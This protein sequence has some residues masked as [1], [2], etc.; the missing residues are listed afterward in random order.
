MSMASALRS[1]L[2]CFDDLHIAAVPWPAS[3]VLGQTIT[4]VAFSHR[5][6]VIATGCASGWVYLWKTSFECATER[7]L[8]VPYVVC[9]SESSG[10][11]GVAYCHFV[12]WDT[13]VCI[14]ASV[15]E[16]LVTH[17]TDGMLRLWSVEEGRCFSTCATAAFL[18]GAAI[19]SALLP[20]SRFLVVASTLSIVVL[21]L[22][23]QLP[24]A[25]LA[26][27]PPNN[28]PPCLSKRDIRTASLASVLRL[29]AA[30]H[31]IQH[32]L[33]AMKGVSDCSNGTRSF[34]DSSAKVFKASRYV[35]DASLESLSTNAATVYANATRSK[36]SSAE[37]SPS[38]VV[39]Q[40]SN[41]CVFLWDLT[42][43]ISR[44]RENM[45]SNCEVMKLQQSMKGKF[46]K[47]HN[48]S[49][50]NS[51]GPSAYDS[52]FPENKISR[53]HV[54]IVEPVA[55]VELPDYRPVRLVMSFFPVSIV[56]GPS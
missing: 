33:I 11:G 12:E 48:F 55:A 49:D 25:V 37:V 22:W 26:F 42:L 36:S 28:C 32:K 21:D 29:T 38:T 52:R 14:G 1:N 27:Y 3:R 43:H 51:F 45:Q 54:L 31:I 19:F 16:I 7:A 23:I 56:F 41:G 10:S 17:H 4:T 15:P 8:F 50:S 5:L 30:S 53:G 40:T 44:W 13:T 2:G 39:V 18:G 34:S 35:A 20:N 9:V 46:E 47:F 6:N 24:C